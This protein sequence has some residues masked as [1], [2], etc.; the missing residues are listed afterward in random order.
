MSASETTCIGCA[1]LEL[2]R[3]KWEGSPSALH[4]PHARKTP[5]RER[6]KPFR[7]SLPGRI[8]FPSSHTGLYLRHFWTSISR[9]YRSHSG[10]VGG[11]AAGASLAPLGLAMVESVSTLN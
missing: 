5:N 9:L 11:S 7:N 1:S 3:Y 8:R 4:P 10:F 2:W 6:P